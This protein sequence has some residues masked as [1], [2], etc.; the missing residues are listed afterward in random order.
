MCPGP[1]SLV[2]V[3]SSCSEELNSPPAPPPMLR[4]LRLMKQGPS[5]LS[6]GPANGGLSRI[7]RK[8]PSRISTLPSRART[9]GNCDY[10]N[11]GPYSNGTHWN[12]SCFGKQ[13]SSNKKILSRLLP[14]AQNFVL[15]DNMVL[16]SHNVLKCPRPSECPVAGLGASRHHLCAAKRLP[17]PS[18]Q[19]TRD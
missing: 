9:E 17:I 10:F 2:L 5:G 11:N 15:L 12:G 6:M 14:K 3:G 1:E 13:I 19:S 4:G 18:R 16:E 7:V 8:T